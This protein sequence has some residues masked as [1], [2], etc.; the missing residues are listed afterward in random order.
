[1]IAFLPA[2]GLAL[3]WI[4]PEAMVLLGF[5]AVLVGWMTRPLPIPPEE[6]DDSCDPATGLPMKTAAVEAFGDTMEEARDR[7]RPTACLILGP[8][9]PDQLLRH[10]HG[11]EF[12]LLLRRMGERLGAQIRAGDRVARWDGAMFAILLKPTPR[13][14]LEGMI[15]LA[16]RLQDALAEPYS[17]GAR[18]ITLDTHIGFRL[19]RRQDLETRAPLEAGALLAE[20]EAAA[21][22]ARRAGSG[23][24]RAFAQ[25]AGAIEPNEHSLARECSDSLEAGQ[26]KAFFCPQISTDTGAICGIQAMPRW[27]HREC[28]LLDESQVLPAIEAAGL[29]ERFSEVMLFETFGA[30]RDF[31]RLGDEVGPASLPLPLAQLDNPKLVERLAWECDRFTI[32]PER[33]CFVVPQAAAARLSEELIDH[34]L[35]ALHRL[36]CRIELAGFGT[37]PVSAETIRKLAP[38]RLRIH[39]SLVAKID[40]SPDN[41]KLVAAIVSMAESLELST[42]ADGTSSIAEHA[43]LG[44]LGCSVV[45]GPAI[46]A[47]MPLEEFHDWAERHRAKLDATPRL[48]LGN[49]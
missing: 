19:V 26:I 27:L 48:D 17:I 7:M 14:D 33:L 4:G 37:G 35:R 13:L 24:I 20:A 30:L 2:C 39:R 38:E 36:G 45:Q 49:G 28:G 5:T 29:I 8:D 23:A 47:P 22:D 9:S 41:Q 18:E 32:A 15:Q 3:L 40:Q 42:L 34:N 16:G 44:Q 6:D 10:L 11:D 31:D 21:R 43:M 1:M 12:D 46:A 25:A